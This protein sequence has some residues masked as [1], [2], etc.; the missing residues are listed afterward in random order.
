MS[1]NI[2]FR[3][4]S[5]QTRVRG[6]TTLKIEGC[7]DIYA[8]RGSGGGVAALLRSPMVAGSLEFCCCLDND[9]IFIT[10]EQEKFR[11]QFSPC[12]SVYL[13]L[14]LAHTLPLRNNE[15][16][17]V[18]VIHGIYRFLYSY[19]CYSVIAKLG[20]LQRWLE[21]ALVCFNFLLE[22]LLYFT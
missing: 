21:I 6:A 9:A 18:F 8:R 4:R 11:V 5:V 1:G 10:V 7:E 16:L 20:I 22:C 19:I 2:H 15:L 17:M 3:I 13:S 12:F 14:G